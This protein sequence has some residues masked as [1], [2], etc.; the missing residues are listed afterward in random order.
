MKA[1]MRGIVTGLAV[2][3]ASVGFSATIEETG[4]AVLDQ[5]KN[6][7]VGVSAVLKIEMGGMGAQEQN[8]E[9]MGTVIDASGMILVS[10]KSINPMKGME[11][12][13]VG[14]QSIKPRCSVSKI[15]IRY[16]DGTEI[17]ARQVYSDS[18]LDVSILK[19]SPE[20]DQKIPATPFVKLDKENKA[21]IM[22][23]VLMIG[24][25]PKAL[26]WEPRVALS[27]VN[28]ITRK[29]RTAYFIEKV[30]GGPGLPAFTADG[31]CL[32]FVVHR[33]LSARNVGNAIAMQATPLVVPCEDVVDLMPAA[34]EAAKKNKPAEEPAVDLGPVPPMPISQ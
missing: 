34:L 17:S 8:I 30:D 2:A 28:A 7:V 3:W 9:T 25:L 21:Q 13:N 14:G 33:T 23:S 16:F 4:R 27:Q 19:P 32:G 29:P 24:R 11:A 18:D 31:R 6:A 10:D 26:N 12:I 1:Q 5:Y 22:D 15:M 20:A